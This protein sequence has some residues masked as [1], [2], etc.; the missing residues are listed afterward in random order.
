MIRRVLGSILPNPG[1]E[2]MLVTQDDA[3]VLILS[4][5]F[6]PTLTVYDARS[7]E[8]RNEI[9]EPGLGFSLLFAP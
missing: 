2:R 6:P 1:V 9:S 4:S 5:T 8:V 3:P 7:G